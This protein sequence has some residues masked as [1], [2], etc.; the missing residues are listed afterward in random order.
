MKKR[1]TAFI[2]M[3][4]MLAGMMFGYG[5]PVFAA[6]VQNA[7]GH[8][9]SYK[10]I[11][12][13]YTGGEPL[14][15]FDAK[16]SKW[17]T[18]SDRITRSE[19]E[20]VKWL[21]ENNYLLNHFGRKSD[22][23]AYSSGCFNS[24]GEWQTALK[25][26][27]NVRKWYA[28]VR[29]SALADEDQ[30]E[31]GN[32]LNMY[33]KGDIQ[34]FFSWKVKTV[35][36]K[37]GIS[38]KSND[39]GLTSVLGELIQSS[40]GGWKKYNTV[41]D[42]PNL[43]N[44]S[45][46]KNGKDLNYIGF[47]AMS[48]KDNRVD[49]YLSGAMLVGRDIK[50]PKIS[51]VRVTAD[52]D[53][54]KE[55]ENGTVT[56]NTIDR[57]DD[58]TVYF[59]VQW[60]EPV[61]FGGMTEE[62]IAG[63]SLN[64]ETLGIDGTSG[65]IAEAPFL[66]FE[67]SK[68]DGKP[69]MV[70]E[71]KIADP[72]NEASSIAQ[73][74]GYFYKFSNVTVSEKENQEL[75]NNIYDI[76]GNKFAADENG[77]Q[78][79][80]KL[81]TPVGGSAKVDLMP[82]GIKNITTEKTDDTAVFIKS[83]E[84][85]GI[86]LK[87]NKTMS[88]NTKK[89]NLPNITLN[90]KDSDGKY[91]TLEPYDFGAD[92]IKYR[93]AFSRG[94]V[95]D[96]TS[97]KVTAVSSGKS[98]VSD[99]SGYSLMNYAWDGNALSPT[100]IPNGASG[101]KS[102]Y[103][104]A[105]D[106][107]YK[108]DFEAPSIDLSVS[109]EGGGIISVTAAA[110]DKFLTGC[111]VSFTVK[112]N[113]NTSGEGISYQ[114]ASSEAYSDSKWVKCENGALIASFSA[115]VIVSDGKG[116]AY[117][118][119]KLPRGSEADKI[120]VT[121]AAVDEA[122]NSAVT[123]TALAA[124]DWT[125]FD[126]LAPTV[127]LSVQDEFVS[128]DISDID[129]SVTY[130]YGFSESV[131]AEPAYIKAS[132]KQGI[133]APPEL[134]GGNEIYER[135]LWI[136]A[137]D[138][139]GNES[140]VSKLGVKYDRTY[141]EIIC[142]AD[143]EKKYLNGEYPFVEYEV[144]NAVSFWY[145]WAE[146]PACVS[147]TASYISDNYLENMKARAVEQGNVFDPGVIT[148]PVAELSGYSLV[149]E[150]DSADESY[151]GDIRAE[152]TSRPIML[153][154]GADKEDG[155]TLI[156]TLEFNT[157]CGAPKAAVRQTRYSTNDSTGKRVDYI[158][159]SEGGGLLWAD[160]N[161][162]N[163]TNT[164]DLYGFAQAEIQ[165]V[166][167]PV[168][169][170]DRVDTAGS[171]VTLKKVLYDGECSAENL[172]SSSV[173][174]EWNF[175]DLNFVKT[176]GGTMSA[177][178]D[179]D[180]KL[181]DARY[182]E[183]V[184]ESYKTVRYEFEYN[185]KYIGG[186]APKTGPISYFSFNNT[187]KGF[188]YCT[189]YDTGNFIMRYRGFD[190]YEKQ[191]T[192]AV[193]DRDGK[194]VTADIPVYAV[195][196]SYPEKSGYKEYLRFSGPAG[197][198]YKGDR[199]YYDTPVLNTV[200]SDNT[201]KLKIHIGTDRENLSEVLEFKTEDYEFLSEPLDIGR[202]LF[203]DETALR[204]VKLYYRFEHP[205]RGTL[206]PVYVMIIRRDNEAPVFDFSVSETERTTN[207]VLV[208]L[209]SV[210]D[211]QT[212]SDGTVVVDTS[213]SDLK[214]G[215]YYMFYAYREATEND[216]LSKIPEEDIISQWIS[217]DEETGESVYKDYISVYPDDSGIMHFTSNGY[218]VPSASD[219]AGNINTSVLING[220]TVVIKEDG[221]DFPCYYIN[222]VSSTPPQF[223]SE[224]AFI[225]GDGKFTVTA[226]CG[227]T[228]KNVYLKFDKAYSEL[229][230]GDS[231]ESENLYNIKNVPGIAS[232]GFDSETGEISAEIYVKHSET[233]P[234]SSASVIIE[235]N[236]G[237]K[238]EYSY[239]FVSPVFGKA[240]AVTNAKNENGYPVRR[241]GET[242]DFTVPVKLDD[243]YGGYALSHKNIPIYSDGIVQIGYTDLFGESFYEN[244][245]SDIFGTAFAHTLKFISGG[246]EI[247]PQTK[248]SADV[249]VAVDTGKTKNLSVD[250]GKSEFVF[251]E[252]GTLSYSLTN[253]EL[254]Q[255]RAFNIPVT[256]VDKTAPEAIVTVNRDIERDAE[257]GAQI[258]YSVSYSVEG[259][260]E[261]G[262]TLV[263]PEGGA[264]PSSIM[265]DAE[266]EVMTYTFRFRDEAGNE[267][268]YTADVSDIDFARR[269]DSKITDYRLTYK[270]PDSSGFRTIGEF[271]ANE[272]VSIGLL[273]REV[274][275]TAEA[276][277]QNGDTVSS[278]V[279]VSGDL[280]GGAKVYEKEKLVV[281]TSESA[282]ERT[283]NLTLT[284]TGS[285]NSIEV[286]VV[287]PG[288]TLDLTAPTGTVN[289]LADGNTVKAYL[290]TKDTDL[291]EDG[292]YV[293]GTKTDGTAFELKKD[294]SGYYTE[295]DKN[296]V[297]KFILIDKAGNIGTVSIA[298]LSI[299][300]EPPQIVSEGW[301]SLFDA[302]NEEEIRKLLE[303]P[304][305]STVKLFI[306]FNEQLS[307]ADA[308][309][310]S[311][312]ETPDELTP[313]DEYVT[314][315][316]SGNALT[317]EFKKN[318]RAK[319]TVYDLRGNALTLWRPEDGPITVIDRDIPKLAEGYPKMTAENDN[320]VKIEYVF[321]DGEEVMLLQNHEDGYKNRHTVA[322]GKNGARTLNF[323][324]R[325]GNVFSDYPVISGIDSLAPNIKMNV[326]YVG[327]GKVLS[328]ND[329]YK[330]G[331]MYTSKNVRILLKVEDE[332]KDGIK[333]TAQTK[334][335]ANLDI[336]AESVTADGK[337]YNY[338]FVVS[339]NGSY[340]ITA[341][342]KWGNEN[343]VETS[344]SVI[345]RT[346]PTVRVSGNSVV[347]KAG[348]SA[349]EAEN[350]ILSEVSAFDLQSGANSPIGDKFGT[351][352]DGVTLA[353]SSEGADFNKPGKYT[354]KITASD[355]LGNT[356][357]K[358]CTVIVMKDVYTFNIG[359]TY[360]YANDVY[361]AAKGKI[362][363]GNANAEAKYY[364]AKGHKTAAQMKYAKGF[365]PDKGFDAAESGY[366]T[367]LVQETG[368]KIYLLYVY[369]Y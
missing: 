27:T 51:S 56:L 314:A 114:A 226:T 255:T 312:S 338:S 130:E 31:N 311:D 244:I 139:S 81:V 331:N 164:P 15:L 270:I 69:V 198:Y 184:G 268:A 229:I 335:G 238:T 348:I 124:P 261:E 365:E 32:I 344:V 72:Y 178:L 138:S 349:E 262:V 50:G 296:G 345:D 172:Y 284:G 112:I 213:E 36:T 188:V 272:Q 125:G 253:S 217:Y 34:Y 150:I 182:Y 22:A 73:E 206:S 205:E 131:D 162:A 329:A 325:A 177:V 88:E 233:V 84:T 63:L 104:V 196:T 243:A 231:S 181:I 33:N 316:A 146:K 326:D 116:K 265:F 209:N 78:P 49:S 183:I 239:N 282:A 12:A 295:F 299:D 323:A 137:K 127:N 303:T 82:F 350:I 234:L 254:G 363:I 271:R 281:F 147:D 212:A 157:F 175:S 278:V 86:N 141:T 148:K 351:V 158:R 256:N 45:A 111:D 133:I 191:N 232:G 64:V 1:F 185:M 279:S 48:D 286:P 264:A 166:G 30:M 23:T 85:F 366:Y 154:I 368:R 142:N 219:R 71:Y 2:L 98:R 362:C 214:N 367:V 210:T 216:D 250:G 47:I 96:G 305:N 369:V 223:V 357:E 113:G 197:S 140:A 89:E 333:V 3:F 341:A 174:E 65:I 161:Y 106:K 230:S 343:S 277:N 227:E 236:A 90:V 332:T 247:T 202:Y 11:T 192:E 18:L 9:V 20:S 132:G 189:Q 6:A 105:P 298:V 267:G 302:A 285:G 99:D 353:V 135:V 324:D 199:S 95:M 52:A 55:I 13:L 346:A 128:V 4:G 339:E 207:E 61:V 306:T 143:I 107:Q 26:P 74:R 327:D 60:D 165:L 42:G 108:I 145:V 289:Y 126:T 259:F 129:E 70:F 24:K 62:K 144:K 291:A 319:L 310:Y 170:L 41:A 313:T 40:G 190:D 8:T 122:E 123:E 110:E 168:T 109:D 252:N 156:K 167:D 153:V 297:G 54:K 330:A 38:D 228:V 215:M 19:A 101:K 155:G 17:G 160:D 358:D 235:D 134:P 25:G 318:C 290:V 300:N 293:S 151:G 179:I 180:P 280:P 257:T 118:F 169:K 352:S 355:R 136:K 246:K 258:I 103:S 91:V 274:S 275:V 39:I 28:N 337:T 46:W 208:K 149:A 35:Q 94:H 10:P 288:N 194:D 356:A 364:Y 57:L 266:S 292:V 320:T 287:L 336:R 92:S 21:S 201:A 237:N 97:V 171:S 322:F 273:N 308:A 321:A 220:R 283:V 186:I 53:G 187:P 260:S 200:D 204:E 117:G 75:W 67:P 315:S 66:K 340:R 59:R 361:T 301:Q 304:T 43:G 276:L 193:F 29:F 242:L 14:R 218:F 347:L 173:I 241:Y 317:V 7:Y 359:G 240:A 211:T 195:S 37:W 225:E 121:A 100:D 203:G 93:T 163:P 245:L 79:S 224:P 221:M 87:L 115:P 83:G 269:A 334:S 222:N 307:G 152:E 248:V 309:A 249:M 176:A 119:V 80:G 354:V 342:D 5:T 251:S 328:G 120:T 159:N 58:R 294:G 263:P 360:V 68:T 102:Q 44:Y 16:V 77:I 76:S